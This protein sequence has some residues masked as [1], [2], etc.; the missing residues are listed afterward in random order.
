MAEL[1]PASAVCR[2]LWG[3]G[4]P[5]TLLPAEAACTAG[6]AA[7]R[8]REFAAGRLCARLALAD[9]GAPNAPLHCGAEGEPLWPVG[10]TGSITHTEGY[11][12]AAVARKE[13][14]LSLGIDAER[15]VELERAEWQVLL[16]SAEIAWLDSLAPREQA[17]MACAV[18][19]AKEAYFKCQFPL[20]RR[21]LEFQDV[22]LQFGE[23]SFTVRSGPNG[24][25]LRVTG[26]YG[27]MGDGGLVATAVVATHESLIR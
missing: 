26:A 13:A 27:F 16:C 5:S 4:E 6:F 9:S 2:E 25:Q 20:T 24:A 22:E 15:V 8:L 17:A 19:S 7:P 10:F 18:F 3:R 11:C 23:R 1:L 12:A 21:W 14:V